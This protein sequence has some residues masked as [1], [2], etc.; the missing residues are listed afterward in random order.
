M[1][2]IT[3]KADKDFD[4]ALTALAKDMKT[5]KSA[6]IRKAVINYRKEL[7]RAALRLQVKKASKKVREQSLQEA[8]DWEETL[9]DGL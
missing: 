8:R 6:V 2:T 7:D 1:K 3:L 9:A 4:E 5:T